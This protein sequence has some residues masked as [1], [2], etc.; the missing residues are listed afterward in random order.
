LQGMEHMTEESRRLASYGRY[1][2]NNL[3]HVSNRELAGLETLTGRRFT[4][5]PHTGLPEAFGFE[6][7]LPAIAGLVATIATSGAAA[8]ALYGA[9]ASAAASTAVGAAKGESIGTALTSGLI[10]GIGSYAGAGVLGGVAEAAGGV[11]TGAATGAATDAATTAA[12]GAATDAATTAATNAATNTATGA[13]GTDFMSNALPGGAGATPVS[14]NAAVNNFLGGAQSGGMPNTSLVTDATSG[15][16]PANPAFLQQQPTPSQLSQLGG[17][18]NFSAYAAPTTATPANA[19]AAAG[20]PSAA[21]TAPMSIVDR[22]S[23]NLG[24]V[25][26]NPTGA[27]D[28]IGSNLTTLDGLKGA[29]MLAGSAYMASTLAPPKK[30]KLPGETPWDYN[31]TIPAT[32]RPMTMPGPGYRPGFSPEARYFADGGPVYMA[33]GGTPPAVVAPGIESLKNIPTM[34]YVSSQLGDPNLRYIG[35]VHTAPTQM[36]YPGSVAATQV[37]GDNADQGTALDSGVVMPPS[38]YRPG[39]SPEWNYLPN[40]PKYLQPA[41][42]P[43]QTYGNDQNFADVGGASSGVGAGS[44]GGGGPLA[45]GGLVSLSK[46]HHGTT[47]NIVHEAK[48]AMMGEHPHPKQALQRFRET[49]GDSALR[50]LSESF[51]E[52][53][54]IRGAGG[55][56]DDLVPGTIE[57]RQKVRLADGEFVVSSDVVSA[58]G[59]GSTDQGVRKLQEMMNRVRRDKT[60]KVK[61]PGPISHKALPA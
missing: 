44:D 54:R 57:G 1:G 28:K 4:K 12:T 19:A 56:L 16:Y 36:V 33:S 8:P 2:D 51:A 55:G 7:M 43:E 58:L 17:N 18:P 25:V 49:F 59:D 3:V 61:Q 48:A 9:L 50:A 45:R 31:S 23:M 20:T 15:G 32:S 37:P 42:P 60:G 27:L 38:S 29:G 39:F 40:A 13:A 52:G 41:P 10:S 21:T 47:A 34:P 46:T 22:A 35:A 14:G 11:A 6:D 24:N 26:N 30:P 53:G 5:N